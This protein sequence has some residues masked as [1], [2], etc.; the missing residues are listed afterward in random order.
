[1]LKKDLAAKTTELNDFRRDMNN[2]INEKKELE[3]KIKKLNDARQRVRHKINEIT[4][5]AEPEVTNVNVLVNILILFIAIWV[6]VVFFSK[7]N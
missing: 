3:N 7:V 6:I 1:M 2:K 4:S 5:S